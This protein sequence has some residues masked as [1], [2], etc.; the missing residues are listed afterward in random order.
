MLTIGESDL[1]LVSNVNYT[2]LHRGYKK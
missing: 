2:N 1:F